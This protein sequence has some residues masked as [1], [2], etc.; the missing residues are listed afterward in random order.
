MHSARDG[1]E[2]RPDERCGQRLLFLKETA[3]R[4][5]TSASLS[6]SYLLGHGSSKP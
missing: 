4:T 1:A 6:L 3:S 2:A 5:G